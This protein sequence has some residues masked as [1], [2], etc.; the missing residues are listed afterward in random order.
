[1]NKQLTFYIDMQGD[2]PQKRKASG[3]KYLKKAS[4]QK[5]LKASDKKYLKCFTKRMLYLKYL[6]KRFRR[7]KR[8]SRARLLKSYKQN[9]WG[10]TVC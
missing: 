5:Y 10:M 6:D 1:M 2:F 3:Q 7:E 9:N 8:R 4:D